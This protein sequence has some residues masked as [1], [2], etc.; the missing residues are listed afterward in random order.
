MP[1]RYDGNDGQRYDSGAGRYKRVI[2]VPRTD[3]DCPER[4]KFLEELAKK[5]GWEPLNKKSEE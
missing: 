1:E 3:D 4:V 5:R 2:T